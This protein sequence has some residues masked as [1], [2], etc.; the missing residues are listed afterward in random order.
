M[1]AI[2]QNFGFLPSPDKVSSS[3][4]SVLPSSQQCSCVITLWWLLVT[5]LRTLLVFGWVRQGTALR[6][7]L[8]LDFLPSLDSLQGCPHLLCASEFSP[9]SSAPDPDLHRGDTLI[10]PRAPGHQPL[11]VKSSGREVSWSYL[12]QGG[13]TAIS[14]LYFLNFFFLFLQVNQNKCF[15][16]QI[17]LQYHHTEGEGWVAQTSLLSPKE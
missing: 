10:R 1:F 13:K 15:Y 6:H 14:F 16:T 5:A 4:N 11:A 17:F 2:K 7:G 3:G 8:S 12:Q 9:G